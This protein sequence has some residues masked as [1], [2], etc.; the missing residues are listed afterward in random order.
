MVRERTVNAS[1][2]GNGYAGSNPAWGANCA[3]GVMVTTAALLTQTSL[4]RFQV[5]QPKL[6][7]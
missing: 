1:Y 2:T 7:R 5:A 3:R 6:G 4:V